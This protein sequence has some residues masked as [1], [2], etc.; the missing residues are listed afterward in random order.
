MSKSF[1]ALGVRGDLIQ[2]LEDLGIKEPTPIQRDALPFLLRDG[3]DF[4]AQAQTGTGKTAA[5]GLPLL[6]QLDPKQPE[7]QAVV[8]APTREL[9]KQIGKQLFRYTKYCTEKVFI[10]VLTGG[11]DIERQVAALARPTHA[12][13]VTPGRLIDLL[14]KKA[15]SLAAV[16]LLVLDEADEMLSLGFKAEVAFIC[17]Q[18]EGRRATWLFSATIPD[19]VQRLIADYMSATAHVL[20]VDHRHVV[21]RDIEHRFMLCTVKEKTKKLVDFLRRQGGERGVVFCR[22]KAGATKLAEELSAEGFAVGVLQGDLAQMERDKVL[23][24]F[25]KGRFQFLIA[26]DVAARGIDVEGLAFVVHHQLP[27]QIEYYTHRSGRTGRAGRAGV[28]IAMIGQ[29]EKADIDRLGKRLGL[30]FS[31]VR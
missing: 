1:R 31:Q 18:T 17:S 24:S 5:F 22:T 4:I 15:L 27:D 25:R 9:A 20:K 23:R 26:T 10:E 2:G 13:V 6:M 3:G 7:I 29:R 28:S 14:A 30:T 12:V 11:D 8:V 16:R 19:G 21:N